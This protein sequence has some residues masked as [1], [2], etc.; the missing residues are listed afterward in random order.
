ME[1]PSRRTEGLGARLCQW[2]DGKEGA[3][4]IDAWLYRDQYR[5]RFPNVRPSMLESSEED[6]QWIYKTRSRTWEGSRLSRTS[7]SYTPPSP[8]VPAH[9]AREYAL[10]EIG[11]GA[12]TQEVKAAYRRLSK[13]YH[14]DT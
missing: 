1:R 5:D 4:W 14:P 6:V 12:S 8:R 11:P 10:L 3:W 13:R 2:D 9:L 7:S